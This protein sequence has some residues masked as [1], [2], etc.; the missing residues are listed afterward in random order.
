M[1]NLTSKQKGILFIILSAFFFAL[2]NALVRLSGDLPSTQKSFFR[3]AVAMIFAAAALIRQRPEISLDR[4]DLKG[5]ILR[6]AFG[7]I[8]V[9]CNYYAIDHLALSDASML[10]K[11]S[12]FFA[13]IFSI[14]ILKERATK[15]QW[16]AIITA[17]IGC[18]F[19]IKPNPAQMSFFPA[20]IGLA[21]GISAGAAYTY[22]RWLGK[23]GVPG[24]LIVF[25][26]SAFSCVC[27]LPYL[28]FNYH[29]MTAMQLIY[30]LLAGLAAAGG[31]FAITAA[32]S[33][34]PAAEISIYDYSNVLFAAI[35]GFFLF[36]QIPDGLSIIGYAIVCAAAIAVFIYNTRSKP[37]EV[38]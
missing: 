33:Y 23:R 7:T 38:K 35:L 15:F 6:S 11:M 14:F 26:F 28:I 37:S 25:F 29:P 4:Q 13:I 16:G 32:Y 5:L 2:M 17:F 20:C 9:L 30:L 19:I 24:K 34:A 8:G 10:N 21:G 12:P 18:L 27:V 36:D 1:E 31:Q 3:N 22:V